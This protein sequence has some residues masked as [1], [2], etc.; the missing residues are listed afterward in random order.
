MAQMSNSWLDTK[1]NGLN[2]VN[3]I[4]KF[5]SLIYSQSTQD[6]A[7]CMTV[8]WYLVTT[9]FSNRVELLNKTSSRASL[10]VTSLFMADKM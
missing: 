2:F 10:K 4:K 8:Q 9:R 6:F 1:H 3:E 5:L 7:V